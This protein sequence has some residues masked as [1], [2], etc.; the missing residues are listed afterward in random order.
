MKSIPAII[1]LYLFIYNP[2]VVGLPVSFA[3]AVLPFALIYLMF[4][5]SL[6]FLRKIKVEIL[7]FLVLI[8]YTICRDLA[9]GEMVQSSTNLFMFL[10]SLISS[11]FLIILLRRYF[12]I[13][14]VDA[15][16]DTIIKTGFL[17]SVI[18]IILLIFPGLSD[19]VRYK[20]LEQTIYTEATASR[21][22][23]FSEGL[24]FSYGIVQGVILSILIFRLKYNKYYFLFI[25]FF[26]ISIMFNARIGFVPLII[27]LIY[28]IV[29]Q[30]SVKGVIY[31]LI[32]AGLLYYIIFQTDLLANYSKTLA[33]SADFFSQL[34]DLLLG[35]S[36]AEF[37]TF[38]VLQE[39]IV[40]PNNLNE[41]Y[42]GTGKFIFENS[43]RTSDIGYILQLIYGGIIYVLLLWGIFLLI[44][45]LKSI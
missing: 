44:N 8:L 10:D 25:P 5:R 20:L 40:L 1:I 43:Y 28:L 11:S 18:T 35:T 9:S 39:M 4:T 16:F 14:N 45:Y 27:A 38:E 24:T 37:D 30:M 33:W 22:F 19:F 29:I 36:N 6:G 26:L 15:F 2:P 13:S 17:A 12:K 34:G 31:L 7:L 32:G 21:T 41:W 23:G 42:F 3:K